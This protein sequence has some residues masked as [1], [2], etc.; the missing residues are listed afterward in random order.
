[1]AEMEAPLIG[2][3]VKLRVE[4]LR[5]ST[6][7]V[8]LEPAPEGIELL[9]ESIRTI[10][11]QHP[12]IV[13]AVADE[14]GVYEVIEG[15]RRL[16]ALKALGYPTVECRVAEMDDQQ[17][18]L[19][20][21]HEN[22]FR[23]DITAAELAR[24]LQKMMAMMSAAWNESRKRRE[25]ARLL[26]WVVTDARGKKHPDLARIKDALLMGEF[27][28]KLPGVVIKQRTRGDSAKPTMAWSTAR[29][30]REIVSKPAI[31][32]VLDAMPP[33]DRSSL[34]KNIAKTYKEL[35]SKHRAEFVQRIQETPEK[36]PEDVAKEIYVKEVRSLLVSFRADLELHEA[37][38][39]FAS[40]HELKRSDAVVRLLRSA[41]TAAGALQR[42]LP[43]AAHP[44]PPAEINEQ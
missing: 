22:I 9:V 30:V 4:D 43:D 41:L 44:T 35:P 29:Q 33:E 17:A 23:G 37:I 6:L 3:T 10:G 8:R 24:G 39:S 32:Q 16:H 20:S 7:N 36:R 2:R 21:L 13:R 38:D 18:V 25:V 11:L 27:Q 26:G 19:A 34:V 1:M 40:A 28:E 14:Q 5:V 15:S 12:L 42:R 31:Q